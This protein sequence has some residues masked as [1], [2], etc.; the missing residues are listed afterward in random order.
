M[1]Q[2]RTEFFESDGPPKRRY[3]AGETVSLAVDTKNAAGTLTAP[4]SLTF[5]TRLRRTGTKATFTLG[6]DSEVETLATGQYQLNF[7]SPA[8]EQADTLDVDVTSS[9]SSKTVIELFFTRIEGS[10]VP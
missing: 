3:T 10:S 8:N 5:A 9:I 4:A 1:A 6:T 2:A 7:A